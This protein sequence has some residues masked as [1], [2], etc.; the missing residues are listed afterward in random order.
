MKKLD[1]LRTGWRGKRRDVN[2]GPCPR[3]PSKYSEREKF[4]FNEFFLTLLFFHLFEMKKN[5]G[6]QFRVY[7]FRKLYIETHS[8][9]HFCFIKQKCLLFRFIKRKRD[10]KEWL[11]CCVQQMIGG[12]ALFLRNKALKHRRLRDMRLKGEK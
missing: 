3:L 12:G 9:Y 4:V 7:D 11:I 5:C 10:K 6:V 8:F 1:V 2:L